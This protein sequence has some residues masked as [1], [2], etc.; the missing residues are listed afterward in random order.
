MKKLIAAVLVLYMLAPCALSEVEEYD[1][2]I[3]AFVAEYNANA[4]SIFAVPELS[5]TCD[6]TQ[7]DPDYGGIMA[8]WMEDDFGIAVGIDDY[9]FRY[10][11]VFAMDGV[12][13]GE[14]LARCANAMYIIEGLNTKN[15]AQ[16]LYAYFQVRAT[17]KECITDLYSGGGISMMHGDGYW[18]FSVITDNY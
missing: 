4:I 2:A 15:Y 3:L 6:A 7:P 13:G 1:G 5:S 18:L 11:S 8:A 14:F 9:W 10:A 17:G 12:D 16:L